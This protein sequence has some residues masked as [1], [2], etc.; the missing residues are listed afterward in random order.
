V[1]PA[2][3]ESLLEDLAELF[4]GAL[5]NTQS[6]VT[7]GS[8]VELAQRYLAIEKLRFGDRLEVTWEIDPTA[9][10]ASVPSLLLQPLVENAVRHGV[11]PSPEGGVIHVLTSRRR[12]HV[13]ILMTN[14]VP[15]EPS[16]PG[17]GMA[18]RNLRERLHL[19]HD[20]AAH[21]EVRLDGGLFRVQITVPIV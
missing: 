8:E 1:D 13:L 6:A 11:A 5:A 21:F 18:L 2:R 20:V 12:D 17:A 9:A 4:R 10:S 14:S 3:T 16:R 7:L 19:M 15:A